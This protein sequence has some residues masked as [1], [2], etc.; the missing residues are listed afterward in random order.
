[1]TDDQLTHTLEWTTEECKR[2]MDLGQ[3]VYLTQ[4]QMIKKMLNGDF[5]YCSWFTGYTP[6]G[7]KQEDI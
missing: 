2:D 7:E 1:M 4:D 3:K 5:L 6:S